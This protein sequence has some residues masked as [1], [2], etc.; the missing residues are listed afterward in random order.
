[1][2]EVCVEDLSGLREALAGGAGRIELCSALSLGGLTP[3]AALVGVA[4]RGSVPVHVLIRPRAGDFLYDRGE[5]EL[6][7][8]D[9]RAAV[10]AGAAGVA[11]GANRP[12]ALLDGPMLQRL[13][14]VAREAAARRDTSVALTLHRAFDL[15]ADPLAALEAVITLGFDRVLTSGGAGSAMAGRQMLAALANQARGRIRI[16]A[17]GGIDPGNVAAVLDTGVDEIHASCQV[18][19]S[20]PDARLF[21]LGFAQPRHGHA[22]AGS[23]GALVSAI[24]EWHARRGSPDRQHQESAE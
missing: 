7:A 24:E 23:V 22:T 8:T 14:S 3:S 21:E 13:V 5:E 1:M 9:I 10:D 16:L 18:P 6:I 2:L 19:P 12:G 15:C 4:V 20:P 17:A 11:I